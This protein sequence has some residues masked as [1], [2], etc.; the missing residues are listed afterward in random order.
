MTSTIMINNIMKD[1]NTLYNKNIREKRLFFSMSIGL[2]LYK[3]NSILL[4]R[5]LLRLKINNFNSSNIPKHYI[6][7]NRF[8]NVNIELSNNELF[9]NHRTILNRSNK[10]NETFKINLSG[11]SNISNDGYE[12]ISKIIE[13]NHIKYFN[14][15]L[16]HYNNLTDEYNVWLFYKKGIFSKWVNCN[17]LLIENGLGKVSQIPNSVEDIKIY[18]Y[19]CE[20]IEGEKKA[21]IQELGIYK[22]I[23]T[24]Y[25]SSDYAKSNATNYISL[26]Y[27]NKR[28]KHYLDM[29][30][31][32]KVFVRNYK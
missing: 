29:G 12:L 2:L 1:L 32:E 22:K 25:S 26:S 6:M 16:N 7:K 8:L 21:K 3:K 20:M 18:N 11:V 24:E 13:S 17:I 4:I 30:K 19:I 15:Q 27:I 9:A 23:R 10:K 14:I 5:D 31:A 28:I